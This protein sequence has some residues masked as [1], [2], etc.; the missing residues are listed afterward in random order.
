MSKTKPPSIKWIHSIMNELYDH[1][2]DQDGEIKELSLELKYLNDFI[3]WHGLTEDF[4]FFKANAH[5]E[6]LD[7]DL[8]FTTYVL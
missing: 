5:E 6:K 8:P 4:E 2:Q 7:E 3:T 1:I